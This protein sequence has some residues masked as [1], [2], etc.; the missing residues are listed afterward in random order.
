MDRGMEYLSRTVDLEIK[1]A[2]TQSARAGGQK[3]G[4][5]AGF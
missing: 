3:S 1:A 4:P 2:G 5:C